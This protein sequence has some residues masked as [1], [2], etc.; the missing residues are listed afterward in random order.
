MFFV[1]STFKKE[2]TLLCDLDYQLT[3][4]DNA[5]VNIKFERNKFSILP[6]SWGS[7]LVFT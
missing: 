3:Y 7:K 6:L 5:N 2:T 1:E 4:L